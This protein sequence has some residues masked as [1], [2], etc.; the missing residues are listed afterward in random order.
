M[1]TF[2]IP[3]QPEAQ[4]LALAPAR[5]DLVTIARQSDLRIA[6]MAESQNV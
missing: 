5:P 4:S 3:R 6:N 2:F 1:L